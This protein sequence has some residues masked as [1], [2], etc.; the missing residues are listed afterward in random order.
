MILE[1]WGIIWLLYGNDYKKY[2]FF[3]SG[4]ELVQDPGSGAGTESRFV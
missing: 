4:A 3:S 1:F 2:K